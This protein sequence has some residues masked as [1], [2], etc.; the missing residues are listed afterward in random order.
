MG[1]SSV[2]CRRCRDHFP[3]PFRGRACF[4]VEAPVIRELKI[5]E[6]KSRSVVPGT[7][8]ALGGQ[9]S[10]HVTLTLPACPQCR[11]HSARFVPYH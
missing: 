10:R 3:I 2:G 11:A 1:S 6:R 4:A 9:V 7:L 8:L 5:P